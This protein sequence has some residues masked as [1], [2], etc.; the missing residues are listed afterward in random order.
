MKNIN[1]S[2]VLPGLWQSCSDVDKTRCPNVA[3][4]L[5]RAER[6]PAEKD[7]NSQLFALFSCPVSASLPI[8]AVTAL[9][10]GLPMHRCWLRADPVALAVDLVHIYMLGN[11]HLTLTHD[12]VNDYL[13]LLNR[14]LMPDHLELFAPHPLRW[15]LQCQ[16]K[17]GIKTHDPEAILGKSITDYLPTG[18]DGNGWVKRL[19]ELQ[20]LLHDSATN[21]QRALH[22]EPK[23]DALWLWGEG[24]LP[25][26]DAEESPW[27]A[28]ITDD[29]VTRGLA[30]LNKVDCVGLEASITDC[31]TAYCHHTG[32]Y[33]LS[34]QQFAASHP[35]RPL[36]EA[37][38]Q[39]M[40]VLIGFLREQTLSTLRLY[41]G[42]GY[43]YHL[44]SRQLKRWWMW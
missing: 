8:A 38:D 30:L 44:T 14:H 6:E 10:D 11:A 7:V 18:S 25:Q 9:S 12:V 19:T 2:L 4:L 36:D 24:D 26:C 32:S 16:E 27:T 17:P 37:M 13:K 21:H 39:Q 23:V 34:S 29:A 40:A 5:K 1:L 43:C 42:D 20:M 22:H 31:V 15:Y 28:V 33:L 41:P 35:D 3:L